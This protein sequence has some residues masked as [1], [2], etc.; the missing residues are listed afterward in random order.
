MTKLNSTFSVLH[1]LS[2]T[3]FPFANI[4]PEEK[5]KKFAISRKK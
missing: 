1:E 5:C 4:F 3:F 2:K